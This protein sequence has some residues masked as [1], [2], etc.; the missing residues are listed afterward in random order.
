MTEA[1]L[2]DAHVQAKRMYNA[3]AETMDATQQLAEAVDRNDQ[4]AVQMLVTMR[5]EPVEKLRKIRLALDQQK[6]SLGEEDGGR[7]AALLAGGAPERPEEEGLANQVA[8]N[9]R[10][11]Q[12]LRDLDRILNRKLAREKTI[13]P[14][15]QS[16]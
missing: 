14:E 10:L 1:A 3:L 7:L 8:V 5:E 9:L 15:G 4:V 16:T 12:Q 13:Y 11:W 6:T 2:L